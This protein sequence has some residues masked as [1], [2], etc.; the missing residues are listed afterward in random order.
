M[1]YDVLSLGPARMDVFVQLPPD[2]VVEICSMDRQRCMIELG[3]GE[4][5]AVDGM[6]FSIGGNTGNNAVGLARLGL[7]P[8]IIGAFGDGWTD[9]Q[10]LEILK[11][12]GVETKYVDIKEGQFG[13]GVVINY[14]GERT[15]LSY[16]PTTRCEWPRSAD[17]AADWIYLTS[18]GEGYEDFYAEAVKW[19][20]EKNVRIAFNPGTR[21]V[22][23]G[24]QHLEYAYNRTEVL[25]VNKEEAEIILGKNDLRTDIK[26]LLTEMGRLGVKIV[27]ITDGQAGTY[28]FDGNKYL[29]M[30]IVPAKVVERTGTGDAFGSGFLAAYIYGKPLEEA[31][32]WGTVNSASVLEFIGPQAGLL[33]R[34]GLQSRLD[35]TA[36]VRVEE[37]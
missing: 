20:V 12:E 26:V 2:E 22:K 30:P 35:Q 18:M 8:A 33:D 23:A 14:Q 5:I 25:F 15:I 11:N 17:F 21:Q 9:K 1:K 27:I 31:L 7:K 16:Y 4:K 19:A 24:L 29:H 34:Q 13:F 10:A 28:A 6:N 3:F 32:R 37:I 36:E